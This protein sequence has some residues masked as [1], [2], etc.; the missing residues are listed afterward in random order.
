MKL[1]NHYPKYVTTLILGS[2]FTDRSLFN[3]VHETTIDNKKFIFSIENEIIK[4]FLI[5]E[6]DKIFDSYVVC[7]GSDYKYNDKFL[8]EIILLGKLK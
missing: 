3:G 4:E 5:I 7:G 8:K 2:S 1:F 6:D